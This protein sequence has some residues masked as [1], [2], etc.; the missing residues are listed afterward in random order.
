MNKNSK[1]NRRIAHKLYKQ[2]QGNP[3]QFIIPRTMPGQ[4]ALSSRTQTI[5]IGNC[6]RL[7]KKAKVA[8][9]KGKFDNNGE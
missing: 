5:T 2:K 6:A 3:Y 8:A 4:T 9:G 1:S 7:S